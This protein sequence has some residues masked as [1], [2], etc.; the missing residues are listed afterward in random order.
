MG[1]TFKGYNLDNLGVIFE[2]RPTIKKPKRRVEPLYIENKDGYTT[3][4]LGYDGYASSCTVVLTEPEHFDLL[5]SIFDGYGQ[6]IRNDDPTRFQYAKVQDEIEF[7]KIG[8]CLKASFDFNIEDPFLYL[9][10][11]SNQTLSAPGTVTN[12]G[13]YK[14]E[15]LLKITGTGFVTVT[16]NGRS[17]TYNFDTPYVYLDSKLHKAYYET[18]NKNRKIVGDFPILDVGSNAISWVGSITEIIVT[19]RTRY[20]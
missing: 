11:E 3:T 5:K 1:C 19:K 2:K 7:I 18:T 6:L 15:P 8:N 17:F 14:S 12:D 10:S 13:T 9:V 4:E 20:L 16:I